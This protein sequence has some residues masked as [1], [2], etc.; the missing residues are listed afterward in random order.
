MESHTLLQVLSD[1]GV[2]KAAKANEAKWVPKTK[3]RSGIH[4]LTETRRIYHVQRLL[5]LAKMERERETCQALVLRQ[6]TL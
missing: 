5:S 6:W 4:C 2:S 3:H 1:E